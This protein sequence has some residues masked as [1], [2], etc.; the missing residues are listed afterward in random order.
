MMGHEDAI[1]IN[2]VSVTVSSLP[3]ETVVR[4]DRWDAL[5]SSDDTLLSMSGG[6]SLAIRN[7]GGPTIATEAKKLVPLAVGDVAVTSAGAL[8]VKYV[9][10]AVVLDPIRGV[11]PS[12]RTIRLAALN[13]FQRCE[14]FGVRHLAMPALGTGAGRFRAD[15]S[16]RLIISA[17]AQHVT[18][19]TVLRQ[20][21]F[22]LPD[23]D[24]RS[25]FIAFLNEA[26]SVPV[27]GTVPDVVHGGDADTQSG[28]HKPRSISPSRPPEGA[29]FGSLSPTGRAGHLRRWFRRREQSDETHTAPESFLR[30]GTED[31]T[32][33]PTAGA[34]RPL[35]GNRYVLLEELGRGGMGIVYLSWD[36][37]LRQTVAIK[38]L[39]PE[40]R[41][42]REHAEAL[43]REAALQIGLTHEGIVRLLNFEPSEESVGPYIIMEYLPWPSGSRWLAEAGLNGLPIRSVLE[44]GISL[45]DALSCAHAAAVLHGDIKPSNIFVHVSGV[46]A[47]LADFGI[48]RAVGTRDQGA[49]VMRLAGTPAY[50]APEQKV[51][52]AKVGPWTDI[53]LLARTLAEFIGLRPAS[54]STLRVPQHVGWTPAA[55]ALLH[56]MTPEPE[57]RPANAEVFR[58]LLREAVAAAT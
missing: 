13:V 24:S 57:K 40:H 39:R 47:K 32:R 55:K 20:V 7:A 19:R 25:G 22:C 36:I 53:Y 34:S 10:H 8:P 49:L 44:V 14:L 45:C 2:G 50:M 54:D 21:V 23:S 43:K 58:E 11:T 4:A 56:G 27:S 42:E 16:A 51:V 41:L 33:T 26:G 52:G 9:L 38:T 48:A 5:V 46:R 37:V 29:L 17:L 18:S 6:V 12:E 35:V 3:I 28:I 15:D 31:A 1:V 30:G